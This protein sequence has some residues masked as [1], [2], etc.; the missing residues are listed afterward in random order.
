MNLSTL[1]GMR[2]QNQLRNRPLLTTSIIS[3]IIARKSDKYD[4]KCRKGK[5][6]TLSLANRRLLVGRESQ[7]QRLEEVFQRMV[8][9]HETEIVMIHGPSGVGK[10]TLVDIF[11]QKLP[12]TVLVARGKFDQL[13]CRAPFS[14]LVSMT[15]HLCRQILRMSNSQEIRGRIRT[16][17]GSEIS[18]LGN[19]IPE[20]A[21]M[22]TDNIYWPEETSK[23]QNSNSFSRFKQLFRSLF[24]CVASEKNPAIFFLDDIQWADAGSISIL[25]AI[26]NDSLSRNILILCAYRDDHVSM[27]NLQNFHLLFHSPQSLFESKSIKFTDIP[28]LTLG[29]DDMN[30]LISEI[31][32]MDQSETHTL[33]SVI[34]DKTDGNPFY[35][36]IFLDMLQTKCL[37]SQ[38][39][40]GNWVWDETRIR[41]LTSASENL[42]KVLESK[43]QL[44]PIQVRSILQIASFIGHEFS[45]TVLTIILFE[46]QDMIE[47]EYSFE[48]RPIEAIQDQLHMALTLASK[49][50]LL[51]TVGDFKD[52]FYKFAHDTIREVLYEDLMPDITERQLLHQRIGFLIWNFLKGRNETFLLDDWSVFLAANNVNGALKLVD[53]NE[54]IHEI[55]LINLSAAKA[56]CLMSDYSLAGE[57]L[58][59]AIDLLK[60]ET[61]WDTHYELCI[62]LYTTA[63][64]VNMINAC[65]DKSNELVEEILKRS[66]SSLDQCTAFQIQ[67]QCLA[68]KGA[69]K[70]SVFLGLRILRDLGFKF[71]HKVTI[72]SVAK[73]YL[74]ARLQLRGRPIAQLVDLPELKDKKM[75]FILSIMDDVISNSFLLGDKFK[76]IFAYFSIVTFRFIMKHGLSSLYAP[77]AILSWGSLLAVMGDYNNAWE[78]RLVAFAIIEKFKADD[79]RGRAMFVAWG[80]IDFWRIKLEKDIFQDFWFAYHLAMASGDIHFAQIG[81]VGWIMIKTYYSDSLYTVHHRTRELVLEMNEVDAK[82]AL[83]LLLPNWQFVSLHL[84]FIDISCN[85]F[86]LTCLTFR[87]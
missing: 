67:L 45:V 83:I 72:L 54:T 32:C 27:E 47:G 18:L 26:I 2:N 66:R 71:P 33:S 9:C 57:Y 74:L 68:G 70:A 19:L 73:E 1:D 52:N 82:R 34:G 29:K 40:D 80:M 58:R 77:M 59:V 79:I 6:D 14:A 39:I 5:V 25:K 17:L 43:L 62:D 13:R 53:S 48:R 31:L 37:L 51:E 49:E 44:I 22:N 15:E 20:L 75:I 10:S 46:E 12:P 81:I 24:R 41:L 4:D 28:L 56:A 35:V 21:G 36:H 85:H 64:R 76:E 78:A 69:M 23:A 3:N 30:K 8:G 7:L 38:Q 11:V 86:Y 61:R 87:S 65:Y 55:L 42:V 60:D 84:L 63:A 16:A 50:G